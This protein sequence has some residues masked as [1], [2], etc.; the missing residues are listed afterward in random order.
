[1]ISYKERLA[2]V[3][4][5]IFDVDGVLTDSSLLLFKGEILRTLNSK[6]G[7]AIQYAIKMGYR[8]VIIT[9]G[10]SLDVK[11]VLLSLG[12]NEVCL[13]SFNKL[14]VYNRLKTKYN[15]VDEEVLYMGDDLPDYEV[16]Q[17]VGV[18]SCPQDACMEI[19]QISHYQSPFNGG[20][21]CVRDVIEQ[22]LRVQHKW[23][24]EKA[25]EW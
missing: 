22:T 5:F 18:A 20:Q 16:M 13:S 25:F 21:H 24:S 10:N 4:T 9:G 17:N 23:F 8:I 3:K 2:K 7:Y 12:V 14:S 6:D 1:M 19:K 15:M 11:D